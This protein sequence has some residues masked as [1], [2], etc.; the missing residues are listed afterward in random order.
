MEESLKDMCLCQSARK[1][2]LLRT[3]TYRSITIRLGGSIGVNHKINYEFRKDILCSWLRK[4][5]CL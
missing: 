2:M 3:R 4:K 5:I 1:R